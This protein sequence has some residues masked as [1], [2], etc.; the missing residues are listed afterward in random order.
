MAISAFNALTLT[1]ALAGILLSRVEKP[2]GMFFRGVNRVID[3]GTA[4][5]VSGLSGL[6]RVRA[7][8]ALVFVAL[9]GATYWVYTRVPTG[10]VP[11][12]DQGYIFIIIQAPQGAS[13]DYT[14]GIEKQV[15]QI[16]SRMPE[17]QHVFGV[18]GF[19]FAGSGAEP[20]HPVRACSRTSANGRASSIRRRRSS[21]SCSARSARSPARMVFPFLPP[22]IKAS[23]TSADSS[24]SCS[25]RAAARS[26]TSP[27]P[28]SSLVGRGQPT[29]GVTGLFTQ[30]TANDPQL[31][32]TIDREQAKSLGMSLSDITQHDADSAG[33]G[34]R[35]RLRLQQPVVSRLRAGGQPV[36][37]RTRATSSA[38]PCGA[39]P[40]R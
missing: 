21:G 24:T 30:F 36:P 11:D 16:V 35:E 8:V 9:L 40:G 1:P 39:A 29:P 6:I 18:G 14:M 12:E 7:V 23:A 13:L 28:R 31:V 15:E 25:I 26:R 2:K 38:T 34:V 10:F 4:A 33:V 3:G 22:S 20:G 37:R 27:T 5:M 17:I 32:V 19:S